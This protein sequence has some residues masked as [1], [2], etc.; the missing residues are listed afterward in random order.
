[1]GTSTISQLFEAEGYAVI[2]DVL[3]DDDV[4]DLTHKIAQLNEANASTRRLLDL[5]WCTEF[6]ERILADQRLRSLLPDSSHPVQCT[7]FSKS[8]AHNWFVALHQDLSIPVADRVGSPTCTGWSQ[9]EGDLFVQ[10][11]CAVLEQLVAIRLHL[12]DCDEHSG[13]LRVVPGSHRLGRLSPSDALRER[14]RRGERPVPITRGGAMV[15]R[16]L[17]LHASSKTTGG[18]P[19]HVLHFVFGPPVLPEGLHWLQRKQFAATRRGE[20]AAERAR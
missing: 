3:S 12:D 8:T 2:Q 15:M 7:L 17:L 13:A 10:P 9:K 18:F 11:P 14:E 16:P 1:M 5:P 4:D 6:G 19:R 20:A